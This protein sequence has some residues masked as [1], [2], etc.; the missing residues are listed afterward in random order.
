MDDQQDKG[1]EDRAVDTLDVFEIFVGV[2]VSARG[3]Y[4][5]FD[6]A[7]LLW[8]EDNVS[9][10]ELL[11]LVRDALLTRY[12]VLGKISK[13]HVATLTRRVGRGVSPDELRG[14]AGSLCKQI[15][16]DAGERVNPFSSQEKLNVIVAAAQRRSS[17]FSDA[18]SPARSG[19]EPS[20]SIADIEQNRSGPDS[21]R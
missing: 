3:L 14:V 17:G 13:D 1:L 8:G 19:G 4:N 18:A 11:C 9:V 7:L 21:E 5:K 2:P 16:L 6:T 12:P 20:G 10:S 15:G